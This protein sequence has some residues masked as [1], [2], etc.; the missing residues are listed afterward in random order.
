M[1]GTYG[2]RESRANEP[3]SLPYAAHGVTYAAVPPARALPLRIAFAGKMQVGKTTAAD[4]LVHRHGFVK[5]ALADPIKEIARDA[6]EWDGEKDERGRRLLQEIGTVGRH[7]DSELWL[8]RL[9]ARLESDSSPRAVVDDVRL[10]REVAYLERRG[11]KVVRIDRPPEL[12]GQSSSQARARHETETE[13]DQVPFELVIDN[14]A[15][16]EDLY[17][18]LDA[19]IERLGARER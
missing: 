17:R 1:V 12:V 9:E 14:D 8:R 16:F 19:L 18:R 4:H 15:A 2:A 6:F 5:Y 11:F 10:A 7:Y 3:T 13:L